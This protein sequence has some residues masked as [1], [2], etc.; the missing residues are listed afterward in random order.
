MCRIN[1]RS[2]SSY[3]YLNEWDDSV[4]MDGNKLLAMSTASMSVTGMNLNNLNTVPEK[5]KQWNGCS[6]TETH[7][8]PAPVLKPPPAKTLTEIWN[9]L[10]K[11]SPF[12]LW[13]CSRDLRETDTA[14]HWEN[15][16]KQLFMHSKAVITKQQPL[17]DAVTEPPALP[18]E[19]ASALCRRTPGSRPT[20]LS[21]SFL[22]C[23]VWVAD[24]QRYRSVLLL[25]SGPAL[26]CHQGTEEPQPDFSSAVVPISSATW[27]CHW[28]QLLVQDFLILSMLIKMKS[29]LI[30]RNLSMSGGTTREDSDGQFVP[31]SLSGERWACLPSCLAQGG[32]PTSRT[33]SL[34]WR[35]ERR[36]AVLHRGMPAGF[37]QAAQISSSFFSHSC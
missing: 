27:E 7:I 17:K 31:L 5:P 25:P 24:G 37:D 35:A 33:V 4:S 6:S 2:A 8:N 18:G 11:I 3:L 28:L 21:G 15:S 1:Y 16:C 10:A 19:E 23:R 14:D 20:K 29:S 32:L 36:R 9:R 30:P 12:S 22:V 13:I 34:C 26:P